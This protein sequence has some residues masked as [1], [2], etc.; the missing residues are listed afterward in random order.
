MQLSHQ[1]ENLQSEISKLN[2]MIEVLK[3]EVENKEM[4]IQR[5]K[6]EQ[7]HREEMENEHIQ[8]I[9]QVANQT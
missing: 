9:Q 4:E 7:C 8:K 3:H 1:V 6:Q 2:Q 5:H